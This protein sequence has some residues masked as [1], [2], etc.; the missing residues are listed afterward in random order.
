MPESEPKVIEKPSQE[1]AEGSEEPEEHSG[2]DWDWVV[3][4][5]DLAL[6][7]LLLFF[8]RRGGQQ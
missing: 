2:S 6:F 1:Y 3:G 8:G 5:G 7:L 4:L